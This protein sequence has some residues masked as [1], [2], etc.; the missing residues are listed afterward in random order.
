M[1]HHLTTHPTQ[2]SVATADLFDK[3]RPLLPAVPADIEALVAQ[4]TVESV[5][6]KARAVTAQG[7]RVDNHTGAAPYGSGT[8]EGTYDIT[9]AHTP[10]ALTWAGWGT[11]L[12]PAHEPI[13]VARKPLSGTVAANVLAH[14]TGAAT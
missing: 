1:G 7:Y 5:N 4:R 2:P 3:L 11:A 8:P 14:G 6:F 10:D 12:K 13:I 9:T